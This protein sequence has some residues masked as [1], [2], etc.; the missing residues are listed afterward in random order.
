MA[1]QIG[2]VSATPAG[3][4]ISYTIFKP[5]GTAQTTTVNT[6]SGYTFNLSAPPVTGTYTLFIDPN[7][8]ATANLT[9]VVAPSNGTAGVAV[10][11]A[12]GNITSSATPGAYAYLAFSATAGENIGLGISN[13]VRTNGSASYN[14]VNVGVYKLDGT[15]WV[16][17]TNCLVANDGCEFNLTVPATG[18][19]NVMVASPSS[20]A[21]PNWT[22]A[23]TATVSRDLVIAPPTG[24]P[25]TLNLSRRGQNGRATFAGTAATAMTVQV[26][27]VS[28]TP[29]GRTV[30]LKILKPDGTTLASATTSVGYT[31]TLTNLPTTG[32]YTLTVD[33]QYGA[34][35]TLQVTRP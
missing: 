32:T 6:T 24:T 5:D 15:M 22:I 26:T 19:Y 4:T 9:V 34:T 16:S 23:F 25:T 27:A 7:H 21:E 18:V 2:G 14:Y 28:T 29:A 1:V 35:A 3:R 33:P 10:D 8:G 31:F 12:S 11:G 20:V 30:S 13:L 17:W